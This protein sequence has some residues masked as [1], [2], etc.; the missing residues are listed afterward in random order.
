M[1]QQMKCRF[2]DLDPALGKE[3]LR[4]LEVWPKVVVL[5]RESKDLL[6]KY[7]FLALLSAGRLEEA[8]ELGRVTKL[9]NWDDADFCVLL[10]SAA[11]RANDLELAWKCLQHSIRD[12][13][14]SHIKELS[15]QPELEPLRI[16]KHSDFAALTKLDV[17]VIGRFS[18]KLLPQFIVLRNH[19]WFSLRDL[20]CTCYVTDGSGSLKQVDVAAAHV[21]PRTGDDPGEFQIQTDKLPRSWLR[22]GDENL[23]FRLVCRQGQQ[24]G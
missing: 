15:A 9:E 22:F 11:S 13:H 16:A 6:G 8:L 3:V 4:L 17:E 7:R 12:L 24:G 21:P 5:H 19:S 23:R 14:F 20:N 10:A 1:F 2:G 18:S